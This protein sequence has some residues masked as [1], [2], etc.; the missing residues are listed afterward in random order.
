LFSFSI[1]E[2]YIII[3]GAFCCQLGCL[4]RQDFWFAC[5]VIVDCGG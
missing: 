5:G 2:N 1:T 3:C 4:R